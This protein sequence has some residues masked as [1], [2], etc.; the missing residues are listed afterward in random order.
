MIRRPPR[1]TLFPYTTLFRSVN[2]R[3]CKKQS[4]PD[5]DSD[6]PDDHRAEACLLQRADE[7]PALE[8]RLDAFDRVIVEEL[9]RYREAGAWVPSFGNARK[10]S[11]AVHLVGG[12]L[13]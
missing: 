5:V 4:T 11:G 9:A 3:C 7:T 6:A 10:Y 8:E 2:P 1:S 12:G 13:D